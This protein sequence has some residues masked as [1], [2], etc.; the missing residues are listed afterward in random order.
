MPLTFLV[1]GS[2]RTGRSLARFDDDDVVRFRLLTPALLLLLLTVSI[3][4]D[5]RSL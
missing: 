4:I 1:G 5:S 2:R 3:R